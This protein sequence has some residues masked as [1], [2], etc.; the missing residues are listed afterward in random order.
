MTTSLGAD[1]ALPSFEGLARGYNYEVFPDRRQLLV[2]LIVEELQ[3]MRAPRRVL[4]IGCGKGIGRESDGGPYLR[5]VRRHCEE[6]WGIDPDPSVYPTDDILDRFDHVA[7][8]ESSLPFES[9]DL[10]YSCMVMEHVEDPAGFFRGVFH[11]LKPGGVYLFLTPNGAHYFTRLAK[12]C[13]RLRIDE[14]VLRAIFGKKLEE[15]H[16]PVRYRTNTPAQ[17]SDYAR[18]AGFAPADFAFAERGQ[19]TKDYFRGPLLPFYYPLAWKRRLIRRPESLLDLFCRV[20]KP[21]RGHDI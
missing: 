2:H 21:S 12:L 8:E 20:R 16:Y 11:A 9:C 3:L 10:A 5:E 4:Y 1:P 15:Y 7:I 6:L 13:H 17:I 14:F 18:R 19:N